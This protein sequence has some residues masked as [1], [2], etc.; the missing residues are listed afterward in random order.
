MA[1][2]S[3]QTYARNRRDT[4]MVL[5]GELLQGRTSRT[6]CSHTNGCGISQLSTD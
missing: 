1:P 2:G 5:C 3:A 4:Y 6:G